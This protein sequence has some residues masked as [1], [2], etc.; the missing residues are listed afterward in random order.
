MSVQNKILAKSLE[1]VH[2]Y[3][4]ELLIVIYI[5]NKL[6][7]R[8]IRLLFCRNQSAGRVGFDPCGFLDQIAKIRFSYTMNATHKNHDFLPPFQKAYNHSI[9]FHYSRQKQ[10]FQEKTAFCPAIAVENL[11]FRV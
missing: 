1:F 4:K 9:F 7:L 8:K 11:A 2:S 6:V 10:E 3:E 5:R